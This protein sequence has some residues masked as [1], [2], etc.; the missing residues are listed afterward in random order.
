MTKGMVLTMITRELV[1]TSTTRKYRGFISY[2]HAADD[3]LAPA[4]QSGL[5]RFAKPWYRL[6][7]M[8]V[9]RDKT[10]LAVTPEL[11]GAIQK[12]LED[13]DYFILLASP[14]AA[15]STWVEQEVDWWIRNR[16][17][18]HLL[19]VWTDGELAW[20]PVL[21]DFDWINTT[22]GVTGVDVTRDG[23]KRAT[24]SFTS[25]RTEADRIPWRKHLA[26]P[27]L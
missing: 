4:L 17:A 27:L 5:H 25:V 18:T 23:T 20:D 21:G 19:I 3:R 10:G 16:S 2:S 22:N 8:R 26:T 9:F 6:R 15:Q 12:A 7:A 14:R 1:T 13:T 11:W 24:T